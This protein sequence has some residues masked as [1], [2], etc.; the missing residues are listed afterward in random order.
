[1]ITELLSPAGSYE[2]FEAAIGAGADAV[3]VGGPAFGARAYAQN[4]T[5]E[6]L[7][8]AIETA[9][10]HN[11]KLYLTVNT[12]LKNRELDDQLFE[13][14]LPYY[15]AG[16][17]A[18]IVQDL[19]V[20]S[21]IRRN[22]PDL[23]IHAST[24]MTVT[25]PEGM[26]FLE[27]KGATRV[28]PARE[29]S[30]EEIS[31]MHKAS[32]LE[33]ETFIHGALCYS[34][35]GQCLMSS[36][37]GG[38]SGNRGRCAQPCRLPYSV[39]MDHRKYKGDKDFCALSLKD[40]CTLDILPDILEAGVMSLKIEGRMKQPAYT[41]GVTAVYRKYLDMYLSGKEYH[42][43]EEDR[44]HLL[45]LFSRGGSCKGYYDMY[46][47]PEMMAFANEKKSGNIQ[48]EIRKIKEKIHGN[49]ILSP[50]SPVILEITCKGK[51]VTAMG[52]EVQF[53]KNQPME[54]QRIRQQMEKLGNTDFQWEDL[55]IEI[56]GRIFVPV[57]VL[58]EVRR[59]ALG[60]MREALIGCQKRAQVTKQQTK[61]KDQT[62]C[63]KRVTD[64]LPVYV[65]CERSDTA[66]VLLNETGITGFYFPFDTME[67]YFSPELAANSEL[68][69]STPHIHRGEIPEKWLRSAQ[70]WLEQGMK[71]FLVRNLE[72]YAVLKK[73][74][75]GGKC[76][77]DASMYTWNDQS[78]GFWREEGVL[79]NT[80][81]LELNEG[82]LKHRDNTSSEL[83]LYGYIPLMLS[84]Q[85]VRK[86]LFGCTGKCETVYL[87]DRY[88]SEFPVKCSCT[89]W[90]KN[91]SEK[92]KYCYN[93][94]YNSIP[95]GLPGEKD[96]VKK[97]N[98]H[99]LRLAFTIEEPEK[100]KTILKEFRTVYQE[101]G[102]PSGRRY[103][104]GHFKRGAE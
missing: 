81:P 57:K 93:I 84:A 76:V 74:G 40:I 7:I 3:Y 31:A 25:G 79:R 20:F 89:P 73:M 15:E 37:F 68:Y 85:C 16:L 35:S 61:S 100:A 82:E 55:N 10:I 46:R 23:D 30:L 88:N 36:I 98:L 52:G 49:L 59:D 11:R 9:H 77:L 87:K 19:G 60:Q 8:A 99:S 104:K 54:E 63:R 95:Y 86:N 32:P 42:V 38:R 64:S 28:V 21:F 90:G 41:A 43:Q 47:G 91:N 97:L 101:N 94:I 71:G 50:E 34:Y 70:K 18:V 2:I 24:Q 67:K 51:T 13:Y 56:N 12:L 69:L 62:A 58:N 33:I 96:Q 4:F 92:A 78:V 72:S 102:K 45:E 44:K 66:E 27:E 53:A 17:D 39:T 22:F 83:L 6:E 80:V 14:L 103:T 26:Q 48:P 29:L 65:S 75:Y 5:Q 1:M